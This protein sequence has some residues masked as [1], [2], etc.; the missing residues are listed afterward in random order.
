MG[1]FGCLFLLERFPILKGM[2]ELLEKYAADDQHWI[3]DLHGGILCIS[4][5]PIS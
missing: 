3:S 4:A 2:V 5:M 1:S